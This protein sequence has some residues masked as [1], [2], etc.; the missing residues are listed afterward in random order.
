MNKYKSVNCWNYSACH[1][2]VPFNIAAARPP[3]P[4]KPMPQEY[5]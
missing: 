5:N 3:M 1:D 4:W 2:M